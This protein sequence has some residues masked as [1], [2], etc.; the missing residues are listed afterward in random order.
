MPEK[1]INVENEEVNSENDETEK[2][3]AQENLHNEINEQT[4]F[5]SL[6]EKLEEEKKKSSE[7]LEQ[8]QRTMA[9]FDNFRKRTLKEKENIYQDTV[10]E[11]V[12]EFLPVLDNLNR[13]VES[14]SDNEICKTEFYQGVTMVQKQ[15]EEIFN[16]LGVEKIDAVG[17]N[18]N[19]EIHNAVMHI[20]DETIDDNTIVE[21][22]Q[23]GYKLKDKVI[24]YS[25]VKVAN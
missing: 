11:L 8:V 12:L 4:I 15:L 1:D 7:Y 3:I 20:E 2:D 5:N 16:K 18:F 10:A 6:E 22:F 19:P 23:K 13:A 9:E 17:E 14:C 24:R 21:E 25:M